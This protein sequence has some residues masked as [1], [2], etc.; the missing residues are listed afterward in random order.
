MMVELET[1]RP[2]LPGHDRPRSPGGRSCHGPRRAGYGRR[3]FVRVATG[4][5]G[6]LVAAPLV[7]LGCAFRGMW[8]PTDEP[9]EVVVDSAWPQAA[10]VRIEGRRIGEIAAL[11][12]ATWR[13]ARQGIADRR[14]SVCAHPIGSSRTYCADEP[15]AVPST[16]QRIRI[17]IRRSGQVFVAVL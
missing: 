17:V 14:V 12:H 10:I 15:L 13:V 5:F 4:A 11:G 7:C 8:S 1:S 2:S 6:T 16:V 3:R 9:I